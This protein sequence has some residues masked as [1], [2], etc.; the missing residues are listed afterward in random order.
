MI[1]GQTPP[2]DASASEKRAVNKRL[3]RAQAADGPGTAPG[4]AAKPAPARRRPAAAAAPRH[5]GRA[6]EGGEL[7]GQRTPRST[8]RRSRRWYSAPRRGAGQRH[9][10]DDGH[11]R[12]HPA[13]PV[14]RVPVGMKRFGRMALAAG[15]GRTPGGCD[16]RTPAPP[17]RATSRGAHLVRMGDLLAARG[18][19]GTLD[20]VCAA[21]RAGALA[22]VRPGI[23]WGELHC[24]ARVRQASLAPW[25]CSSPHSM[26][27]LVRRQRTRPASGAYP[28]Q[29]AGAASRRH[30]VSHPDQVRTARASPKRRR[31]LGSDRTRQE[32]GRARCQRHSRE[33]RHAY[34]HPADC[35]CRMVS[36]MAIVFAMSLACAAAWARVPNASIS[37]SCFWALL[38]MQFATLD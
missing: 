25:C 5:V 28:V 21:R 23:E 35:S 36:A 22:P 38:A 9:G 7:H 16:R 6:G 20:W 32:C 3:R 17:A 27:G 4:P 33:S 8:R 10:E 15:V 34:W 12:Y 29:L 37:F 2:G 14:R 11:R 1:L 26:P 18:R 13:A 24:A 30:Q 31:R 19:A